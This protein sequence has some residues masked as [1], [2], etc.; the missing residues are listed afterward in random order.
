[1]VLFEDDTPL[2]L[3]RALRP[4]VLAKGADYR[5]EDVV[6][7]ADVLSWGGEVRLVELV[8]GVSTT[9][10]ATRIAERKP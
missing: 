2:E 5:A 3:I 6:G 1:V 7:G 8:E 10:I 4:D 9:R